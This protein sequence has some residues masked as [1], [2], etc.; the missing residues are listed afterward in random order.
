M[1]HTPLLRSR[2]VLGAF[3]ALIGSAVS[4]TTAQVPEEPPVRTPDVPYVPT[5]QDVVDKMLEM[6]AVK[7]GEVVY[8]LGC[9]D[10]RIV[11]TAAKRHGARGVGVDIN[12]QRIEESNANA[13]EAGVQDKV[14]FRVADLFEMKDLN[15]ADVVTL[16]LLPSVNLKLRPKLLSELDPGKRV[17]S[18][19]F[20]MDDWEPDEHEIVNGKQVYFWIIP[21]KVD[22]GW[23]A[24]GNNA[25]AASI[26]LAQDFQ[27]VSGTIDLD[28]TTYTIKEGQVRGTA[29]R[30][31]A[32]SGDNRATFE[33]KLE[34]DRLTGQIIQGDHKED[35]SFSRQKSS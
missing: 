35:V 16:Y 15:K 3:A 21:A 17:V 5:P 32:A 18:H 8:D 9:G 25:P 28:G 14:E 4:L 33:G 23:A 31:V 13:A 10:G 1:T 6:A 12:P 29:V 26:N 30:L 34:K 11:I 27:K 22:G 2:I 24:D 19:A 7:E 20:D